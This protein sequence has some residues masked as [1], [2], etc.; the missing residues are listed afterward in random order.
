MATKIATIERFDP[1]SLIT[2]KIEWMPIADVR[3]AKSKTSLQYT[4]EHGRD[5]IYQIA[6]KEDIKDI[7]NSLINPKIGYT[8]K[9]QN[10]FGRLY[11]LKMHKHSASPYIRANFEL[12]NITVR[13]LFV[14]N[15]DALDRV[16]GHIHK[17]TEKEYGYRFAW[18]EASG[19]ID[20]LTMRIQDMLDR[21]DSL[22]ALKELINY[23]EDR[24]NEIWR[25]TW[26][27]EE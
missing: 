16:E 5:A 7:G 21:V 22:D 6:L 27:L 24:A 10:I 3:Q 14:E 12:K 20:G 25:A 8:G 2:G 23:A 19:G 9:S 26:R 4:N 13:V 11:A 1:T 15:A 17:E 18:K